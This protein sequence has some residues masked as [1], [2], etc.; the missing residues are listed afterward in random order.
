MNRPTA[1]LVQPALL[2]LSAAMFCGLLLP[3]SGVSAEVK[4]ELTDEEKKDGWKLL[5]DGVSSDGWKKIG[6][7]TFPDKGWV[8]EEGC[9]HHL[10]K[11]GGGDIVTTGEH[12]N[13]EL[14][15]EWKIG[16]GGNSGVKYRVADVPGAAF[17]PEMQVLDDEHHPDG[18]KVLTSAGALYE[19]FPANE[20]KKL[21]PI[22]GFNSAKLIVNGNH[23]E[24]WLNGE[25]IVEYEFF[26]D[27][28]KAAV[29]RSKFKDKPK[30]GQP[31]KA[32]IALQDH[33][34]EVWFRNIK[35]KELSAAK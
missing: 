12:E 17:G 6:A 7:K 32:H 14:S 5:F 18:K 26:S 4:A 34:D 16:E 30:Y 8:I 29:A 19:V 23:V 21:K 15:L 27:E 31:A 20:K 1:S 33:G 25:K 24:H 10:K 2:L 3:K 11:G 35:I 28:W 22:T 13:F 9:L